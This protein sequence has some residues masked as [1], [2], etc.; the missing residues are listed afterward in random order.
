VLTSVPDVAVG[1]RP[2]SLGS[3]S[4]DLV[5][6]PVDVCKKFLTARESL[7]HFA[8]ETA[9]MEPSGTMQGAY[10]SGMDSAEER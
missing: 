5:G 8:V 1:L 6:K 4:C 2:D 3:Y 9:S 10:S 7:L